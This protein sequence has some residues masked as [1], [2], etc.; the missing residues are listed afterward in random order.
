MRTLFLLAL[1]MAA[2]PSS[3]ASFDDPEWPCQQRKVPSLTPGLMWAGPE[4]TDRIRQLETDPDIQAIA[5]QLALRR[6]PIEDAEKMIDDFAKGLGADKS[7]KLTA[8]FDQ[9]FTLINQERNAVMSGI[10]RYAKT[11]TEL[12]KSIETKRTEI[13]NLKAQENPN[14]DKLEEMED[15]LIWDERIFKE[16]RQSLIYV[17]ETPVILEKRIFAISRAL[18]SH[19]E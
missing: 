16:R 12:S 5:A 6:I 4:I 14:L 7:D 18:Q 1:L 8:V 3:A 11:Q 2:S 17:C 15:T 13:R 9:A 10:A 19:L